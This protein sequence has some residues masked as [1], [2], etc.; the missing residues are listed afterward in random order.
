MSEVVIL[1]PNG[2]GDETNIA[3]QTPDEGEHW[4]KIDE[5]V[6][7]TSD[8]LRHTLFNDEF[9]RDLY[10]FTPRSGPAVWG[11]ITEVRVVRKGVNSG[12]GTYGDT[13]GAC[14]LNGTV[15]ELSVETKINPG[16][17]VHGEGDGD[18]WATNPATG[19]PW[20]WNEID[21]AQF[22]AAI[23][24]SEGRVTLQQLYVEVEHD[25]PADSKQAYL[26]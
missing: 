16:N 6:L 23:R 12:A 15:Y 4:D 24:N 7:D 8:Y 3:E 21:N 2:P 14:K 17:Y 1:R 13:K 5:V 26:I 18:G 20:K 10:T 11:T 9:E 25:L 19:E 22:G